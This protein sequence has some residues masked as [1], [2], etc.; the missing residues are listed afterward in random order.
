MS[1]IKTFALTVAFLATSPCFGSALFGADDALEVTL[2]GPLSTVIKDK[3]TREEHPFTLEIEGASYAVDVRVRG[4]SRTTVCPFPPLRLDF[5]KSELDGTPLEGEDKLKLVTHCRTG[6]DRAQDAV[7][8]EYTAYRIFNLMSDA[9][10]R[11]R[12]LK[13]R[14]EDTAG[15]LRLNEAQ[16]GFLIESDEGLA[17]RLGGSVAEVTAIRFSDMDPVQTSRMNVFQY[18]IGN[19][20]WSL[21]RAE[22]DETCCHNVD[23]LQVSDMLLPVPYDFDLAALTRANYPGGRLNISTRR[24]YAGYCRT[25]A[26][27]IAETVDHVQQLRRD[28]MAALAESPALSDRTLERR[29]RFLTAYFEEA[30]DNDALLS[31]FA[32]RCVGR[33]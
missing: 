9:S 29:A 16:Y 2:S 15:K 13:V 7:L 25:P 8:N 21:V 12:L 19:K 31:K 18:L 22:Y 28:I 3:R 1:L 26:D 5:R 17:E 14:Y 10:Y 33:R 23:V 30:A 6:S 27:A 24:E 11:V 32:R 4:N 20:D